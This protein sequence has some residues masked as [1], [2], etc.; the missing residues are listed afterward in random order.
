MRHANRWHLLLVYILSCPKDRPKSVCNSWWR[1]F[2]VILLFS[3]LFNSS[4]FCQISFFFLCICYVVA[5]DP[6]I[7][8]E[9][10]ALCIRTFHDQRIINQMTTWVPFSNIIFWKSRYLLF[11]NFQMCV[12][13]ITRL[14]R[15][16]GRLNTHKTVLQHKWG[17]CCYS[18]W[19]FYVGPQSLCNRNFWWR[20]CVVTFPFFCGCRGFVIDQISS[21][22]LKC[23]PNP[24]VMKNL[25]S[26]TL[27]IQVAHI[28]FRFIVV[29]SLHLVY[30]KEYI[31]FYTN[32]LSYAQ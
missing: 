29:V 31:F 10:A 19:P 7:I 22:F 16:V 21:F 15:L 11:T 12:L 30:L 1:H 24:S 4:F 18:H 20:Y 17:G 26:V 6:S 9:V 23:P 25:I 27:F 14:L 5:V 13:L 8:C 28:P 2:L 32:V 3:L